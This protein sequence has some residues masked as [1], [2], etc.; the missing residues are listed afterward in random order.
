MLDRF[1]MVP[2]NVITARH[3]AIIKLLKNV[4]EGLMIH[5]VELL[6]GLRLNV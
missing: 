6:N 2:E 1:D 3:S 5:L 4:G